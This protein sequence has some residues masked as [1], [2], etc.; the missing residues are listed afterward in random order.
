[1]KRI[2]TVILVLSVTMMLLLASGC[3]SNSSGAISNNSDNSIKDD[4]RIIP[5]S[6]LKADIAGNATVQSCFT[7]DFTTASEYS[8]TDIEIVKEQINENEKNI[9]TYSN[10]ILEN[11]YFS[12]NLHVKTIYNYYEYGGWIM[13]ELYIEDIVE[14]IPTR[15]PAEDLVSEYLTQFYSVSGIYGQKSSTIILENG[16]FAIT[17]S[18][19]NNATSS[20]VYAQY[21]TDT[22]TITGYITF[23]FT[24]KGW[25][26]EEEQPEYQIVDYTADYSQALGNFA[27]EN[28]VLFDNVDI[29]IISIEGTTV[30]YDLV[31]FSMPNFT[32]S[33]R[34][35]T[36]IRATFD[37]FTGS[38]SIGNYTAVVGSCPLTMEYNPEYDLW[39]MLYSS[40][41]RR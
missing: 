15:G 36:G 29:K 35:G 38:F 10:I 14:I 1:M 37:P 20:H 12:I 3:S 21:Q 26:C 9:I 2:I 13:D 24:E 25:S 6:T 28:G 8:I 32:Y 18:V 34:T 23:S 17:E 40:L 4:N 41:K 27:I 16:V 5:I 22:I 19:L 30:I 39:G 33:V 31:K 7:S 11:R